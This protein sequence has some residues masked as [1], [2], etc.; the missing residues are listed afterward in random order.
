MDLRTTFTRRAVALTCSAALAIPAVAQANSTQSDEEQL[1]ELNIMLM[2]TS[3]RCRNTEHDFRTEYQQFNAAHHRRIN[4]ASLNV[5]RQMEARYG[6]RGSKRALDKV[7]VRIANSYGLGHPWLSCAELKQL[8]AELSAERDYV[9]LS[10][11]AR[12]M[13]GEE[14]RQV[15]LLDTASTSAQD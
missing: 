6:K 11:T 1:R 14:P 10:A 8:A 7:D 15:A 13:L 3:L 12:E 2:V 9:R 4:S 5:R